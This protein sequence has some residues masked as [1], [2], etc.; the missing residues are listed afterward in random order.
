MRKLLAAILGRYRVE[1]DQPE[2]IAE[3]EVPH[4]RRAEGIVALLLVLAALC[5]IAFA[6]LYVVH[7]TTQDLGAT[8]G[9]SLAFLA[10]ALIIAGKRVVPQEQASEPR[11]Q[12]VQP[13]E[14]REVIGTVEEGATGISRRR[15]LLGASGAA[16]GGLGIAAAVPL[17]SLGPDVDGRIDDTP[18][19]AGRGVVDEHGRPLTADDI[20]ERDFVTGFPEGADTRELGSPIVIVRLNPAMLHLP[21]GRAATEWAPEGIVAYSKICTHAGCAIAMYRTPL[22]PEHRP[23][24]ALVCP[25][26]YSTFDPARGGDPFEGPAGRALP[27]LPLR[28]GD[29]RRLFANG[30]FSGS[31]GPS[32]WSVKGGYS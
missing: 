2:E 3:R 22:D 17:A 21:D 31:I 19:H 9:A 26:H 30:G 29:G 32:W 18:W 12:L 28:I 20:V 24:P 5:A 16:V 15:L 6:V 13:E 14:E 27:Q 11:H 8:L 1:P 7:W 10:A 25:C 23:R 4:N